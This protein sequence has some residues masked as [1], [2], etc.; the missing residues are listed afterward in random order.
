M[1]YQESF[2]FLE[3][4]KISNVYSPEGYKTNIIGTQELILRGEKLEKLWEC[5]K[6]VINSYTIEEIEKKTF[7]D[8]IHKKLVVEFTIPQ[9]IAPCKLDSIRK[10]VESIPSAKVQGISI[11]NIEEEDA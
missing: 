10:I 4:L 3:Q 9:H 6:R 7:P 11:S 1:N 2:H 8:T 5:T